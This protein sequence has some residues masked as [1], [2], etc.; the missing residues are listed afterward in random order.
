MTPPPMMH[1]RF[2]PRLPMS[3]LQTVACHIYAH[4]PVRPG[5]PM[6]LLIPTHKSH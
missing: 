1:A 5:M 6:P 3:G 2:G 4:P